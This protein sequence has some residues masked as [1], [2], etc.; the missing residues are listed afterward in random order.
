MPVQVS[1]SSTSNTNEY[2]VILPLN[3]FLVISKNIGL[4]VKDLAWKDIPLRL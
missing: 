1:Q 2:L 4:M 3:L